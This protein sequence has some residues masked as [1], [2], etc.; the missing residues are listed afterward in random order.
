VENPGL[1][2]RDKLTKNRWCILETSGKMQDGGRYSAIRSKEVQQI[3]QKDGTM[4]FQDVSIWRRTSNDSE[5]RVALEDIP[6][7]PFRGND[8]SADEMGKRISSHDL[9]E[10]DIQ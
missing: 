2:E 7:D 5:H 6:L 9:N 1:T 8:L 3:K 10:T 4:Q